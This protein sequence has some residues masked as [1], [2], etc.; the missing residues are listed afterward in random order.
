MREMISRGKG[1]L[2]PTE[3]LCEGTAKG[4]LG[5]MASRTGA[6]NVARTSMLLGG[7]GRNG[8]PGCTSS[9]AERTGGTGLMH[10]ARFARHAAQLA[11]TLPWNI[12]SVGERGERGARG[13]MCERWRAKRSAWREYTDAPATAG[14]GSALGERGGRGISKARACR[15]G[16][17]QGRANRRASN[18]R[19]KSGPCAFSQ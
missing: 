10:A 19:D 6:V 2:S 8:Y 4:T 15:R 11:I 1:T 16:I 3:T 18:G 12:F 17:S 7:G 9:S 5:G 13:A 14:E